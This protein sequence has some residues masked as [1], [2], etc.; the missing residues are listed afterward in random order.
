VL[1]VGKVQRD[2]QGAVQ[3]SLFGGREPADVLSQSG[4]READ[5]LIAVDATVVLQAWIDPD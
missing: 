2:A 3:F 4:F 1:L 5:K